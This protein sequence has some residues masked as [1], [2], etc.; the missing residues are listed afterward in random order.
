[1]SVTYDTFLPACRKTI[2]QH[3]SFAAPSH[4]QERAEWIE[5]EATSLAY[6]LA[7]LASERVAEL[8]AEARA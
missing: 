2:K 6:S 5:D 7:E 4:G 8:V 3:A 1:M